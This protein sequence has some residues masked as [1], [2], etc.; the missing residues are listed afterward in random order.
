MI[1]THR[2]LKIANMVEYKSLA[3]IGT[4]HA[5]LPVYLIENNICSKVVAS[6]VADG[7]V[8]A[9]KDTVGRCGMSKF[10]DIRKGDGLAT[11]L[12][13]EV[14]TIVIAGMGG[15]LIATILEKGKEVANSAKEIILQPMTHIPQLREFLK[16]NDFKILD[17][18]LVGEK[19]KIYT[20][21]KITVGKNQYQTEFDFL[22]SPVLVENKDKL[23]PE[24]IL[25]LIN[26]YKCEID[27]LSK[28]S[29]YSE[30]QLK[31]NNL[32]VNELEKL[33]EVAK[34]Y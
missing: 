33:Y 3:D 22:I 30:E 5:K 29:C 17:E 23:L 18:V 34:N 25:K 13:G 24:Y 9:C 32:I 26:K 2:L 15:D 4:D 28:A 1:L 27:G 7:P 20:I 11:I 8:K 16:N 31:N 6:D 21:I 19:S 14:E 12:P 10:V